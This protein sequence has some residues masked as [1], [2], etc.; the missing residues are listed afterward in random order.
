LRDSREV[1]WQTIAAET[2]WLQELYPIDA[3]FAR[4]LGIPDSVVTFHATRRSDPIYTVRVFDA[5]GGEMLVDSFTPKYVVRPFFD[6]FPEYEQVRVTTG[7]LTV[8]SGP[9]TIV[10]RRIRTDPEAFWDH[11]QTETY[12]KIVDYVMDVQD[13]RPSPG[14][15][16]FFDQLHIELEMSEPNERIGVDEE[17]I[18]SLEALHEDI[19]FETLTLFDLIGDRYGVGGL[20]FAGRVLPYILPTGEGKRGRARIVFTGKERGVPELALTHRVRSEEP[21]RRTYPLSPLPV[22]PPKLRGIAV[23]AVEGGEVALERLLFDVAVPD[24]VE[25]WTEMRERGSEAAID[26]QLTST[27]LI[28]GMTDA[29]GTLHA[30]GLYGAALGFDS[31]GEVRLRLIVDDTAATHRRLVSVPRPSGALRTDRP[32]L[33]DRGFRYDGQRLVQWQT[34]I[35]PAENDSI[36]AKLNTFPGVNVYWIG[37][38]YLGHDIFAADFLPPHDAAYIS[39]AKLNAWKPTVL[40]SGRQHANEVSSTSHILR[41]GELLATDST[42]RALLD[43]VNVVLHPITNPDGAALAVEMQETNPDFMLH[44]GYLG[45]LGVDA[46]AGSNSADPI[47]PESKVRPELMETWLPDIYI[48]MHGY[49]SHEW[50]QYFAGYSAWVRSRTGAQRS[51]WAPRGWFIPGFSWTDDGRYPEIETAQLAILDSIA[52]AITS[53]PDVEA[54]NRRL[55]ARYRK[56]GQQDVEGFREHFRNGILVYMALRG[57]EATGQGASNPRI[58]TFSV[59]TEA[60]DETA[61]GEWLELVA[62]AGLAHGAALIRYLASGVNDVEVENVAYEGFVVR[63][64]AREKPVLPAKQ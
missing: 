26:R 38:S 30:A 32:V 57:R 61:R 62:S 53:L 9:D 55:Y 58:N 39:Q 40:L 43:R 31:V 45:A 11:L 56:Y 41:L 7:W 46:T 5:A 50:V 22:E 47:Y 20:Q 28:A 19:Y 23:R 33:A 51:W 12:A 54:M 17:V 52:Q 10:D 4:E 1:R 34:P 8:V 6:L 36:L 27:A 18:S 42:Y 2:R 49:P 25:R 3:V 24:S 16:P 60:P 14:N 15:A 64:R 44:A 29:L 37:R 13:G 59:T 35:A 63:S 48:N 21:F